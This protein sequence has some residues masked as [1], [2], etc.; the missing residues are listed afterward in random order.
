MDR[1]LWIQIPPTKYRIRTKSRKF[2]QIFVPTQRFVQSCSPQNLRAG[3]TER[4]A[5][6]DCGPMFERGHSR[7]RTNDEPTFEQIVVPQI[8]VGNSNFDL[9][10]MW[11]VLQ[12][13]RT[14][15]Q[16]DATCGRTVWKTKCPFQWFQDIFRRVQTSHSTTLLAGDFRRTKISS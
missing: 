2:D 13:V 10:E 15:G 9:G 14:V 7:C 1:K 3:R 12:V 5:Q 4:G 11:Q 8:I 16:G 6:N